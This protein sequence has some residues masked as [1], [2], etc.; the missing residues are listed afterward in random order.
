MTTDASSL[1]ET[2][3][4]NVTVLTGKA[5]NG[6][7]NPVLIVSPTDAGMYPVLLFV[8][9]F[10]LQNKYY[11]QLLRHISSHGFIVVA[12]Q[13]FSILP[14]SSTKD[15]TSVAAVTN[16]LPSGLQSLLPTDV[17]PDLEKLAL[18]GHSRGGHTSF[19]LALGHAQ[20][21]LKFTALI[22]IDPVAGTSKSS[23]LEPKILNNESKLDI[24]AL[25]I[26]SGL[27]EESI[28]FMA[29]ACAP[30]GV[31][32][33]EFYNKCSS[34]CY[35]FVV[36]KYGHMDMLDDDA[37][38][39]MTKCMCKNGKCRDIMRRCTAGITVAFLKA[40]IEKEA[41]YLNLIW[42]NPG[43]AP[44]ELEPVDCRKE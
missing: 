3:K 40:Y 38:N 26:G 5:G 28:I 34:P 19:S 10:F 8:H 36:T 43:L 18:S 21:T 29:P 11:T 7:S 27:G 35:H 15:I 16:W 13:L 31:N 23:Q 2:G 39:L 24:P 32:H 9:G 17:K 6:E 25:V 22:G 4:F 1:F 44:G 14:Q 41:E 30:K 12:P 42:S 20:T 33:K 37:F